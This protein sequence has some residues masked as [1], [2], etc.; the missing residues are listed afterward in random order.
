VTTVMPIARQIAAGMLAAHEAGVVHRD[1]K[2][3]NVMI[4][5]DQAIIMDFG[6][7][8]TSGGARAGTAAGPGQLEPALEETVTRAAATV[9]GAIIGTVEY[10]AP[11]QARGQE[12]DQRADIYAFGL[13]LYDMLV[14]RRRAEHAQSAIAELQGRLEHAPLPVRSVLPEIP[15]PVER[16]VSKCVEPDAAKRYQTTADLV[17]AIERLDD[18]GKLRPVKR[19]VGLP[20]AAAITAALLT[21]SGYIWWYTRPPV[22]HDPVSVLI[23]DFTNSTGDA[24]I[25]GLE[26]A[27]QR[28]LETAGF[29]TAYDRAGI[30]RT[31]GVRP[32]ETLDETTAQGIAVKQGVGVVLSGAV[33]SEGRGYRLSVRAVRSVTNE[34][35]VD[36]QNRASSK[37]G[38]PPAATALATRVRRALGDDESESAQRFA[39]ETL[40][41][42]SLD[43][44]RE[45][46]GAMEALSR[47]QFDDALKGFSKAVELDPKFGLAYAGMAIASR[48]LDRQ[49]D[50]ERYAKE[51]LNHLEGM[52]P[53]ERLRTRGLFFFVTSNYPS[54][55]KEYSELVAR[56]AADA[57][58]RNNLALCSTYLRD[59]PKALD[60][61]RFVVTKLLPGR[62]LYRENLATYLSYA[63]DFQAGEQEARAIQD[64]G[65]FGLLALAFAQVGQGQLAQAADTYR[66]AGAIDAQGASYMASGL[67]DLALY[68]GR[69]ADAERILAE[70]AIADVTSKDSDRAAAKY[71]ALGYA[72]VQ[73]RKMGA[74]VAAAD[75]ALK[76]SQ[77][78]KTRFL[79]ARIFLEAGETARARELAAGLGKQLLA[80]P[81]AYGMIIDAGL[82][83]R[84][85]DPNKAI[86]LLTEAN[87]LFDTWVGHFDLGRAY[88]DVAAAT[89]DL[90]AFTQ[91]DSEFDRCIGRRG[92]ALALFLDEEPTYGY[93]PPVYFY[94]ARAREGLNPAGATEAYGAYLAIRGNSKEDPLA[95]EA[96]KHVGGS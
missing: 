34:L 14:G 33:S 13:I 57:A 60:Q 78:V 46:A 27:M 16:L 86:T 66:A 83:R 63:S 45:Y 5:K 84:G 72:R 47:S 4:A 8:R 69:F 38:I 73:Q 22:Q 25:D 9:A 6:I 64:P 55:V 23:A 17:A 20:L 11:E 50:A 75:S 36:A 21:L 48:N 67:G 65:V 18:N 37:E 7:A 56:Y 85:G 54:C 76:A 93:L 1:L 24:T 68:E 58:A 19:V 32:P 94:R 53:R 44:V 10:M 80:E 71:A 51:S 40:S 88:L 96:R 92:E 87:A 49:D 95:Q 28:A 79:A 15:E 12:V 35:I 43:V 81:R 90:N 77:A 26:S 42:T 62:A 89:K 91:A 31:L 29:I 30:R 74:A 2:P 82:A 70:G 39:M 3:A 59:W 52:T 41:A 61:M